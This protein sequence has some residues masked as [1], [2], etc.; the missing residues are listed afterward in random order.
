MAQPLLSAA[1]LDD[2]DADEPSI[3]NPDEI[4]VTDITEQPA[5]PPDSVVSKKP[6]LSRFLRCSPGAAEA[7]AISLD[8]YFDAALLQNS[9]ERLPPSLSCDALQKI[10]LR[11]CGLHA[12]SLEALLEALVECEIGV[13]TI[14][15]DANVHVGD[16]GKNYASIRILFERFS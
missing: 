3:E 4:I 12:V 9:P 8:G 5:S 10:N 6:D 13:T 1:A 2:I 15:L 14:C 16:E 11:N 7:M